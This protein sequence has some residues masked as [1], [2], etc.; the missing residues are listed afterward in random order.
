MLKIIKINKRKE[1]QNQKSENQ[2]AKQYAI[3]MLRITKER[4]EEVKIEALRREI[5]KEM[6]NIRKKLK[7]K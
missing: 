5:N 6:K 4:L 1:H 3:N 7:K 2:Y